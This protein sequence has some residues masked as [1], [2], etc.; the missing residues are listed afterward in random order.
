MAITINI[1]KN[2]R[3]VFFSKD[4]WCHNEQYEVEERNTQISPGLRGGKPNEIAES[5]PQVAQMI[6]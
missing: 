3:K 6:G 4:G 1:T 5:N 2:S